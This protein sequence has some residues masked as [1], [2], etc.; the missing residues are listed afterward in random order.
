MTK[1]EI[2]NLLQTEYLNG[3]ISVND[4]K[5]KL[6]IPI[7]WTSEHTFK[8]LG[9]YDEFK[10]I[11]NKRRGLSAKKTSIKKYGIANGHNEKAKEKIKQTSLQKYGTENPWQS[12][13]I[14]EKSKVTKMNKYND[15]HWTNRKKAFETTKKNGWYRTKLEDRY[16]DRLKEVYPDIVHH[17]VS[18]RYPFECDF[19][20]PSMDLYIELNVF[21]LHG[22]HFFNENDIND[23]E[24]LNKWKDKG[25]NTEIWTIRDL[26]K[27][28]FA[29]RNK[30][31]YL[32][33]WTET[34]LL[35]FI[36]GK[37]TLFDTNIDISPLNID[38]TNPNICKICGM[39]MTSNSTNHVRNFHK[40]TSKDYYDKYFKSEDEGICPVCGKQT[41]FIDFNRGYRKHCSTTCSSLDPNVQSKNKSTC[42]QK[43]GVENPFQAED[44]KSNIQ[45]KAR[46]TKLNKPRQVYK[47]NMSEE[48]RKFEIDHNC[49]ERNTLISKYGYGWY[50]AKIIQPIYATINRVKVS[51]YKNEDIFKIEQYYNLK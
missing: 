6:N 5:V 41:I 17:Y 38:F 40:M 1:D 44:I 12:E 46:Q 24:K 35:D 7:Y 39:L 32:V 51:F 22:G 3:N 48:K 31:N 34:E 30:L 11:Q 49:T 28:D 27:R 33:L 19:Y 25:F 4:I 16:I 18:E 47:S 26:I 20:I 43:Y 9:I 29:I 23:I 37:Y 14:K 42:I 36:N 50:Q 15:I 45:I 8:Y 13:E 10:K 21:Y 2:L